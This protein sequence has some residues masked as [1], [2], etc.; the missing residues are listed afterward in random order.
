MHHSQSLPTYTHKWHATT[1]LFSV[2]T[3]LSPTP[4][5][6][7]R[8]G[9]EMLEH[10]HQ[11]HKN[12]PRHFSWKEEFGR[13]CSHFN[14]HRSILQSTGKA[15]LRNA[16]FASWPYYHRISRWIKWVHD[17]SSTPFTSVTVSNDNWLSSLPR[18][19]SSQVC[20]M[21][22]LFDHLSHVA[23]DLVKLNC[24]FQL[25]AT[26]QAAHQPYWRLLLIPHPLLIGYTNATHIVKPQ[27]RQRTFTYFKRSPSAVFVL[28]FWST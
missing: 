3:T 15:M 5:T 22:F 25:L 11:P 21:P 26:N 23:T 24:I 27:P 17:S 8:W 12:C 28:N 6:I 2:T 10:L 9:N 7:E 1:V 16:R 4:V 19:C 14:Y 13:N 18:F 20:V